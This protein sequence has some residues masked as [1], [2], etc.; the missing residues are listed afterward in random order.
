MEDPTGT[1]ILDL[2]QDLLDNSQEFDFFQAYRILQRLNR[3]GVQSRFARKDIRVR[4]NLELGYGDTDVHAIEELPGN[5]GYEIVT[6]LAGLYGISSPL[7]DFYSEELLDY[8]WE[9]YEGPRA[10]LDILHNHL[11]AKLFDAWR[12]YRLGQNTIEE[13]QYDYRRLIASLSNNPALADN[14]DDERARYKLQFSGLFS[15]HSKT[16]LGLKTLLQGLLNTAEVVVLENQRRR[17]SIPVR[18]RMQLGKQCT[19]LGEDAH[20]GSRID[21]YST[22]VTVVVDSLSEADYQTHFLDPARWSLLCGLVREY[23]IQPLAVR[24]EL[25][26]L[27]PEGGARLGQTWNRLGNTSYLGQPGQAGQVPVYMD[28]R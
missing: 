21:D 1:T 13:R 2:K 6:N 20:L 9:G 25:R 12:L 17:V 3:A 27:R 10:F 15:L 14:L 5:R 24:L 26:I 23:L 7:P 8:E 11:L 4:P 22:G 16:A 28:I 18:D 19:V